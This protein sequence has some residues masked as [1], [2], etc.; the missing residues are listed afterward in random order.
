MDVPAS[1]S[2]IKQEILGAI[3]GGMSSRVATLELE[4]KG[5]QCADVSDHASFDA[6]TPARTLSCSQSFASGVH[7]WQID[8]VLPEDSD[9]KIITLYVNVHRSSL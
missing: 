6:F 8:V 2:I 9:G 3:R 7:A 1:I 5:F 4:K